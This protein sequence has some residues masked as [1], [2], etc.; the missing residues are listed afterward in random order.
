LSALIK[1]LKKKR[2]ESGLSLRDLGELLEVHH[3][4]VGKVEICERR[5]DLVEYL[6][7][8]KALGINPMEGLKIMMKV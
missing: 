7:Y 2:L 5:L 8:C 4:I 6:D 3:S 1:W